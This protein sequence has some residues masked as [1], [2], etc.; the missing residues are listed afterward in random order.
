MAKILFINPNKWGR[1][2]T[3][4][5]ISSHSG[6]L[7]KSGHQTAL[8]DCTFYNKWTDSELKI[9]TENK[10]FIP[11]DYDKKISWNNG[12]VIDDL[13]NTIN[14]YSPDIIFS[15]GISSHIHGEG[16][17]IN[18]QYAISILKTVKFDGIIV[19]GG[20]QATSIP[21]NILQTFSKIS[22]LISGESEFVLKQI[23]DFYPN[24]DKIKKIEGVS[25]LE[26]NVFKKNGKQKIIDDLDTIAPYDYDIYDDQIFLRPYNGRVVRAVDYEMSRGCVY[27]C[28]YCVETIIQNYY[29]FNKKNNKGS[30]IDFKKYLRHKSAK[31]IFKEIKYLSEKKNIELFRCQDTNFLTISKCVLNELAELIS[32]SDLNIKLYIETRAE[33]INIKT[34]ELLK[35]LKVDGVGMGLELSDKEFREN[36]LNRFV[37]TQKIIDAFKILKMNKINTTAY[38]I[39]GL[40][41]QKEASIIDTIKLNI[42]LKPN[43]SSVAYYSAYKGTNLELKSKEMFDSMPEKMDAQI[44][45]SAKKGSIEPDLLDFYKANF[46][47]LIEKKLE[48]L[49]ELKKNWKIK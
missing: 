44:R 11:T 27:T 5:W 47:L 35:R 6:I 10:Q 22:Y 26:K 15:S 18:I 24:E 14:N 45:T 25:Y 4:I 21:K 20:I 36:E 7:K 13:K 32:K 1:G 37:D 38:N 41:G 2:I 39:I 19:F 31:V 46:N 8:F 17:Y 33:G 34:V 40:P 16:E 12:N 30:L 29:G 28:S 49:N 43:V 48:N 23:A 42:D 9:N 3:S